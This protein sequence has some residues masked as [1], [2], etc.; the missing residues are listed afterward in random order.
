[1]MWWGHGWSWEGMIFGGLMMLLFWGGLI[2][3][4]VVV[5]R[6][7]A[8]SGSRQPPARESSSESALDILKRRY[9]R[10]EIS[11]AEYEEMRRDLRE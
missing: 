3:L 8:S 11:K 10:G 6:G 1:M 4:A 5:I 9:A 7:L 2:A